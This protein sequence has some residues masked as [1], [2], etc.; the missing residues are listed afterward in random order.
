MSNNI[1]AITDAIYENFAANFMCVEYLPKRAVICP[2]NN[3]VDDIN[4]TMLD[5]VP[6]D[7]KIYLSYDT[8]VNSIE[9]PDDF[10]NLYPPEFLNSI[11][12]NNFSQH[13]L[14]LKIGVPV[15]LLCYI[16]QSIGLCNGTR[17][18]IVKLGDY[19][20]EGKIIA[21]SHVGHQVCIPRII[22]HG[23]S[24]KWPFSLARRE[25]PMK[26]CYALTINKCQGQTLQKVRVY[27]K[28]HVFSHSQ[29]YVAVSG[30]T[31]QEGLKILIKNEDGT[32]GT[33][34][35]NIVH[36]KI[37]EHIYMSYILAIILQHLILFI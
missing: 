7:N 2:Q 27:L 5:K 30:V 20:I 37:I 14:A 33:V 21:G 25:Y 35:K 15:V 29:L 31:P 32:S 18:L 8:I 23:I 4:D 19:I 10:P 17:L 24:P 12:L 13:K 28:G 9:Q 6:G 11:T 16:D 22:L 26:I 34:T 3:T 36:K 1:D